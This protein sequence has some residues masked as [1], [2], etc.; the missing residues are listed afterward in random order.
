MVRANS[1]FKESGSNFSPDNGTGAEVR[2]AMKDIFESLR[3][4]NSAAGDPTG[5]AN[6]APY[7]L[8]INTSNAGAN[9]P[10]A[11]LKIY[12]GSSFI[13]L[14]NVLN[15]NFGFLDATGG[16]LTGPL[17]VDD[18]NSASTPAL[19]FD[20][21]T[22]LGLFRKSANVMGFSANGT[23]QIEFDQN[24]ITLND[25]NEVRFSEANS[26][27]SLYVSIKAPS[28]VNTSNKTITL[29]DETGT[30][31]TSAT[32]IANNNLANSSIAVGSTTINLGSSATT[33]NG[34]STL[35][36]TNLQAT[37]LNITN[38]LDPSGNNGSTPE[39]LQKGRA[40]AW[41]IFGN[42]GSKDGD[43]G[44][45]S[46]TDNGGSGNFTINF[47]VAF[48]NVNYAFALSAGRGTGS[49][50]RIVTQEGQTGKTTTTFHLKVRNDSGSQ[51]DTQ[52]VS[53]VF[54]AA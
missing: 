41:V 38:I 31:L 45:S 7:Q 20:G 3:T 29:P 44:V 10:E 34:L 35:V 21:D 19:S 37:D 23:Q 51:T 42:D 17:L 5:A 18:S 26:N 32:S 4:V 33:I 36:A 30:L 40:K 14:G 47:A 50:A 43:F 53:A 27:G 13:T 52:Q 39:Q 49:G 28:Q 1:S 25:Q 48:A 22:D 54:F 12:D 2:T 8:H 24:G 9:P 6:L 11:L 16:T 46:V 15:T